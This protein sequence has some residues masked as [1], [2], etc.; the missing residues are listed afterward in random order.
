M[1]TTMTGF[2]TEISFP[3]AR[4][5]RASELRPKSAR[6]EAKE[7]ADLLDD[8]PQRAGVSVRHETPG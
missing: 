4:S 2:Q 3:L 8:V 5:G 1:N 7:D 6:R